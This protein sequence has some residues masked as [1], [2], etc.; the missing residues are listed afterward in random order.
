MRRILEMN[1]FIVEIK[2]VCKKY[3]DF[4]LQDISL[5]LEKGTITG[6]VG[7][8][9]AGKTT[10]LELI[11][12]A[13]SRDSGE[14]KVFGFDNIKYER[15]V[16]D[17]IGYVADDDYLYAGSTLRSMAN[18]YK[19]IYSKWSEEEFMKYVDMWDLSLTKKTSTFSKGMKTKAMFALTM[20]HQ[21]DVLILDEP[22]SGL[23]P[24]ARIELLD[25]L[26][27]YVSSG[28][29]SVLFSTHITSDLDK[30]ADY[31]ALI[32][33]GRI[34]ENM[35]VN[36]IEEKYVMISGSNEILGNKEKLFIGLRKGTMTFEGLILRSDASLFS[37]ADIHNPNI[38]NI[39]TFNI[40][41]SRKKNGSL[42]SEEL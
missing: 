4:S 21:P 1:D 28:E 37:G 38:E 35:S 8:N 32:I 13:V 14:I 11:I 7:E 23:D 10:T 15:E 19:Y 42:F 30:V 3:N 29:K 16:R 26:R 24:V 18:V 5:N 33:D 40:W 39:L 20:G 27:D 9:G 12:N 36:D 22:T 17:R 31:I 2:N 41:G 6:F 25:V 34:K